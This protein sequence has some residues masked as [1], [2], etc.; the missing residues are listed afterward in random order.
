[1]RAAEAAK[2]AAEPAIDE[3]KVNELI[4][5]KLKAYDEQRAKEIA[6]ERSRLDA[7]LAAKLAAE[8]AALA[9]LAAAK[10]EEKPEEKFDAG[11]AFDE[12]K[13]ELLS[14]KAADDL[15]F[16][17]NEDGIAVS[18]KTVGETVEVEADADADDLNK[19]GIT[20]ET[21]AKLP[22]K[23]VVAKDE[24]IASAKE[25]IEETLY[26]KGYMKAEKAAVTECSDAER[27][28]GYEFKLAKGKI[29]SSPEEFFKLIRVYAKSFVAADEGEIA[30]KTLM[31]AFLAGGK[32]YIYLS[33]AQEGLNAADE[34]MKAEGLD[35]FMV[36][37]TADDCK[38]AIAAISQT[39]RAN[40]LVRY[41]SATNVKEDSSEKGFT[42][43]LK[44]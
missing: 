4:D 31:K 30:E 28:G 24:D 43:T 41:P 27:K 39:M 36:V 37:K 9:I 33:G 8:Q 10:K 11:K 1:M 18:I 15:D 34:A 32:I 22:V 29:A 5:S 13:A 6:S 7:E 23:L 14:Y 17:L 38:K 26:D 42:Y 40:N 20:V 2:A 44:A 12:L 3:G 25:L 35:S 21:G 16:G 19:K